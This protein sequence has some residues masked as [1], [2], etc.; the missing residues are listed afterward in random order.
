MFDR[1]NERDIAYIFNHEIEE[2]E[3]PRKY[4]EDEKEN[5]SEKNTKEFRSDS[6]SPK[7][8]IKRRTV[9]KVA[10]VVSNSSPVRKEMNSFNGSKGYLRNASA[11]KISSFNMQPIKEGNFEENIYLTKV[12]KYPKSKKELKLDNRLL[13]RY[14]S[15]ATLDVVSK[16]FRIKEDANGEPHHSLFVRPEGEEDHENEIKPLIGTNEIQIYDRKKRALIK[17]K[18]DLEKQTHGYTA[19]LDGSRHLLIGDKLFIT[20]GRDSGQEYNVVLMFDT[21]D[22]QLKRLQDMKFSHSYHALEYNEVYKSIIVVG[23]QNNKNCELFDLFTNRWRPLP[24]LN[25]PRANISIF[26]DR[27][28]NFVYSLFGLKG[29]IYQKNNYSD[30]IEVLDLKDMSK[31]W[32]NLQYNNKSDLDYKMNYCK[33]FHLSRDRLLI[34]GANNSRNAL[35]QFAVFILSKG[36]MIKVDKKILEEIRAQSRKSARLSKIVSTVSKWL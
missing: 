36:E 6:K 28:E 23:G 32:L 35:R 5:G 34:Y 27:D 18:L 16:Y 17:K 12:S 26:F 21:K 29:D 22:L 7:K 1:K 3:S 25:Y 33:I 11:E 19:F 2:G 15:Y 24:D 10:P 13:R 30:I 4:Q 31:G 20:G 9:T 8:L 14:F